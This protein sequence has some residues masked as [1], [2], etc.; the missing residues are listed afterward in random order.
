MV[1][2]RG[3]LYGFDLKGMGRTRFQKQWYRNVLMNGTFISVARDDNGHYYSS[4]DDDEGN[5]RENEQ[6]QTRESSVL[7]VR[8]IIGMDDDILVYHEGGYLNIEGK[9]CSTSRAVVPIQRAAR[10]WIRRRWQAR[11]LALV[12]ATHPRLGAEC[13]QWTRYGM[14]NADAV[15]HHLLR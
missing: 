6:L 2:F 7:A 12:M 13:G 8:I 14:A 11:A 3:C 5:E 4:S 10:G 1:V 15:L 9:L